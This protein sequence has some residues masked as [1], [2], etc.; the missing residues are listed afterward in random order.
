MTVIVMRESVT[1]HQISF[2]YI[3]RLPIDNRS[4]NWLKVL[5]FTKERCIMDEING[6]IPTKNRRVLPEVK[7]NAL[8]NRSDKQRFWLAL[9]FACWNYVENT[10]VHGFFYLRAVESK[11]LKRFARIVKF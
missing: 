3:N 1:L 2:L 7:L 11:G 4:L 5:L 8:G 10:Q 6:T 9:K